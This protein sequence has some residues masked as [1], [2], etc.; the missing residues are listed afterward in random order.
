MCVETV[1]E[2]RVLKLY[3]KLENQ[4]QKNSKNRYYD[5]MKM[6]PK[7]RQEVP[8]FFKSKMKYLE[9]LKEVD[10]EKEGRGFSV[11]HNIFFAHV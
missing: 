4:I 9:F 6:R 2:I 10:R 11:A 1:L 3:S 8:T 5:F 7:R